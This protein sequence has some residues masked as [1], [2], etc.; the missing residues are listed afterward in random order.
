M[1]FLEPHGR[2]RRRYGQ[3]DLTMKAFRTLD[4]IGDVRGKRVLVRE[5]LNAPMDG[6][7]ITDDSRL[8]AAVPTLAELAD[9]GAIVL[10][11]THSGRPRAGGDPRLSTALMCNRLAS[12]LGRE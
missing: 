9:A 8:R 12:L 6:A 3:V 4:D 10:G 1:G 2:Y 11:L 5:D 7:K